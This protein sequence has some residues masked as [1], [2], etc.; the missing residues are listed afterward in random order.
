MKKVFFLSVAIICL[1]MTGCF[2]LM[3]G[4]SQYVNIDSEP[5]QAYV[6]VFD[7]NKLMYEHNTPMVAK[8]ERKKGSRY[9]V[10]YT[11]EGYQPR[12][13][14]LV[15]TY[16]K[17]NLLDILLGV[18]TTIAFIPG[19]TPQKR[20]N[21]ETGEEEKIHN[22]G[23]QW[24]LGI[25][26]TYTLF[27]ISPLFDKSSRDIIFQ[28]D[29]VQ[30]LK[31]SSIKAHLTPI[32]GYVAQP[33][34]GGLSYTLI[35]LTEAFSVSKGTTG[36]VNIVIPPTYNGLPVTQIADNGFSNNTTMTSITIPSSV[37]SIGNNA[38]SGSIRLASIT[39][40]NSVTSIGNSVFSGCT[41]LTDITIPESVRSIGENAFS[42]CTSLTSITIPNSVTIIGTGAFSGCTKLTNI[43]FPNALTSISNNLFQ[44]CSSITSFTISSNITS[45][46]MRAFSGC[47]GLTNITIPSN[48]RSIGERVF[49]GCSKLT[50]ITIP[51]SVTVGEEA[52]ATTNDQTIITI[53]PSS[54]STISNNAFAKNQLARV[55]INNG[56]TSIGTHAFAENRLT[57]VSIPST[58]TSIGASAFAENRLTSVTIP[59]SV[60]TI[61]SRAFYRNRLTNITIPNSVTT[62]GDYAFAGGGSSGGSSSSSS[63]GSWT[64]VDR[65]NQRNANG[66]TW[67]LARGTEHLFQFYAPTDGR[68]T[69]ETTGNV[70]TYMEALNLSNQVI[71]RDDDGGTGQNAKLT[72]IVDANK[73]YTF[74]VKGYGSNATGSYKISASFQSSQ[75]TPVANTSRSETTGGNLL[76]SATIGTEV[77]TIG[78]GA[79]TANA[80]T[81]ITIPNN[82]TSIGKN[83]FSANQLTS[84]T[85]SNNLTKIDEQTFAGNSLTSVNIP[86]SVRTIANNAFAGN[87]IN[88]ISIG[89]NVDVSTNAFENNFATFYERFGKKAGTYTWY[90]NQWLLQ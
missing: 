76:T 22:K 59:S 90:N 11:K 60:S 54:V 18:G 63:S 61:G 30:T 34:S 39:I 52:F 20:V 38:F 58:V 55:N 72:I 48:V 56:V 10:I 57:S 29:N 84:V 75:T 82:V 80:L 65:L 32:S 50:N 31:P 73:N 70:D 49:A 71:G 40:P 3:A 2:T 12:E 43:T 87:S 14:E 44:N 89:A 86:G 85:I 37:K 35:D 4:N 23:A 64:F 41:G 9:R 68:V 13:F 79:F 66:T 74:K 15:S 6:R 47:S 81:T 19:S 7:G 88:R 62:I 77:T 83:A 24:G 53:V 16:N 46:G 42:G 36:M 69:V 67:T 45:I 25:G 21:Q 27:S 28:T 1:C 33:G 26:I 51:A 8:F 17:G 78:E 5:S